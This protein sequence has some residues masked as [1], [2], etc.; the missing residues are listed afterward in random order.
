ML[1]VGDPPDLPRGSKDPDILLWAEREGRI[2]VSA[3]RRTMPGHLANHLARGQHSPGVL[4]L[5]PN[6]TPPSI[7]NQLV[8]VAYAGDPTTL[9]DAI[10][11]IP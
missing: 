9:V 7:I 1:R 3:D 4:L 6:W 8:L 2:L 10:E 11:F 5:R